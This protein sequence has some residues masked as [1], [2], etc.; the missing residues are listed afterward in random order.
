LTEKHQLSGLFAAALL[1]NIDRLDYSQRSS[2]VESVCAESVQFQSIPEYLDSKITKLNLGK[3]PRPRFINNRK[4]IG[5]CLGKAEKWLVKGARVRLTKE[6][7]KLKSCF[8]L[9][10]V[11]FTFGP[12]YIL[13][14]P[15]A[16]ILN[17]RPNKALHSDSV[18]FTKTVNLAKDSIR[19]NWTLVSSY[20]PITYSVVSFSA[21]GKG[22]AVLCDGPIPFMDKDDV[23]EKFKT[24]F[25]DIFHME[26]TLFISGFSPGALP[27]TKL[28]W[29][30]RD[31]TAGSIS[32]IIL[33]CEVRPNG[34]MARILESAYLKGKTVIHQ[35]ANSSSHNHC[36][37]GPLKL[38]L[39]NNSQYTPKIVPEIHKKI[40]QNNSSVLKAPFY[41]GVFVPNV[42]LENYAGDLLIHYT[43]ACRGPWPGQS[44]SEYLSDLIHNNPGSSHDAVDTLKR[45]LVERKI[46]ACGKWTRG[47][48]PVVSFTETTPEQFGLICKWRRGLMRRTFEPYA[49]AF[50]K[51]ALF[52]KGARKVIYAPEEDF[53]TLPQDAKP[54][55][56]LSLSLCADWSVEKKWRLPGD[57]G[58]ENMKSSDWFVIAPNQ[59]DAQD[60]RNSVSIK[61]LRI[62]V[63]HFGQNNTE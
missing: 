47:S 14:N 16:M 3:Q 29:A 41:K 44:W 62:Y 48:I 8:S 31:E 17:S 21:K 40:T 61:S 36:P 55:F 10:R 51:K 49:I 58:L 46:R 52:D 23:E 39:K 59:H 37:K 32:E 25:S 2:L 42:P 60:L 4:L 15:T 34:N 20:G 9:F 12:L 38:R 45:I 56:Q 33:P 19:K 53:K 5:Y 26:T 35:D 7:P 43:R 22:L 1:G 57:L 11:I 13:D 63:S 6:H 28:R 24:E 27:K 18:W 54:F 30:I 50:S